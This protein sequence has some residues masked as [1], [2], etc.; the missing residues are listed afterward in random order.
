MERNMGLD[1]YAFTTT[2]DTPAVD[3]KEPDDAAE[4]F[5]WRKHPN[6]H[7]WMEQLYRIKRGKKKSFNLVPVRLE[8]SDL[9][10]LEA[11]VL[12]DELPFIEGLFFGQSCPDDKQDDLD[13][14]QKARAALDDEKKV[15]YISW[16]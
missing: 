8:K 14:I 13:F 7:G 2:R 5:Y 16:W 3:F 11:V 1:M 10:A 12:A 15:Y 6:L 9:D 4:L